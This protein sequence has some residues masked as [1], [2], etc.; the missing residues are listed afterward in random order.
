MGDAAPLLIAGGTVLD[1]TGAPPLPATD[2]LVV[3]DRIEAVGAGAGERAGALTAE[4][5]AVER[6]DATGQTVMPGLI[7]AHCHITFGEPAS[8]DELFFHREQSTAAM[9]AA[10]NV[11]K[12]L[13]AGVTG[14]LDADCLWNLGPALRDAIEAGIVEGPRMTAGMNALL[15]AAGG[16]AGRLIPDEGAIGYAQV[17][18]DRDEMVRTTRQQ[19]KH[20]ADW[21]K[22]HVTG[23]VPTHRGEL[24]V[25]TL[26]EL[27]A[28]VET[29]AD[30]ETPTVA[31]CRNARSTRL[32][33]E[34]GV[35]L[36]LHASFLDDEA[37]EAVVAAGSAIAPTF[38]FLANLA[39][40]GHKVGAG[41]GQ[42]DLFRGEIEATAAMIRRAH[43]AGVPILSGSESGFALTPYGHWHARELEV[44]VESVGLTP[45]EAIRCA[46]AN[47]ARALRRAQGTIGVVA[48]GAA[49]DLLVVDGDP[50]T[51]VTV[52]ADRTSLRA[53]IS[54]GRPVDL[55]RP[56]PERRPL[57]GEKVGM[58]SAELLTQEAAQR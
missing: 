35:D 56:W 5:T 7:D 34:A 45:L 20:G 55:D 49:A 57:P 23:S 16:T 9:L 27:R 51:D 14:F 41:G 6:I 53:V 30:L 17:V 44:L 47:G 32:A 42:V 2:V 54:R 38:T 46:T 48:E 1:G 22:I 43:D 26:D 12:L 15:T 39:D 8:N 11:Q 36:I 58:W 40:H 4:G 28:V 37:L 50:S 31:H 13:L 19:I 33:A 29:A 24:T 21:I 18:R 25:W 52:L 10:F 3:G